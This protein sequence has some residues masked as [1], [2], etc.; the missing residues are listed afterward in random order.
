[1]AQRHAP[2][3]VRADTPANGM[4]VLRSI[5]KPSHAH[6]TNPRPTQELIEAIQKVV[7]AAR[8]RVGKQN[9][10]DENGFKVCSYVIKS[11]NY[12]P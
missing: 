9:D 1:M 7:G 6:L 10:E 11:V 3:S 8:D 4:D 5:A 2:E 12:S